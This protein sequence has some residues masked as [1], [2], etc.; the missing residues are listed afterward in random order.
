MHT[1]GSLR[2]M[3]R[4]VVLAAEAIEVNLYRQAI[5]APDLLRRYRT[6]SLC[7]SFGP[8][9]TR[10]TDREGLRRIHSQLEMGRT[11]PMDP[12]LPEPWPDTGIRRRTIAGTELES[13]TRFFAAGPLERTI[14]RKISIPEF[15]DETEVAHEIGSI[16]ICL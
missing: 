8:G 3:W 11:F 1:H 12:H 5:H 2:R 7:G 15:A 6:I 9:G 16:L 13:R 14:T 10:A 4:P